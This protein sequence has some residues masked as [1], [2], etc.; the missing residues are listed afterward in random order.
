MVEQQKV[1][2]VLGVPRERTIIDAEGHYV[3][4]IEQPYNIGDAGHIILVNKEGA[5]KESIQKAVIED[6]T[7]FKELSG[8]KIQI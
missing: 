2:I 4:K 1:E 8:S 7:R 3:L 5:T 6:A